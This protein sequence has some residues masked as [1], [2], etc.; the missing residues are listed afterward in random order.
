[1]LA[2]ASFPIYGKAMVNAVFG[3]DTSVHV[4]GAKRR[5]ASPFNF[6]TQQL[7]A[8]VFLAVTSVVGIWQPDGQRLH[9]ALLWN[10]LKHVRPRCLRPHAPSARAGTTGREEKGLPP[11]GSAKVAAEAAARAAS[12]AQIGSGCP[13]GPTRVCPRSP[14]P[15]DPRH[16]SGRRG[17]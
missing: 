15:A 8:F 12:N 3:K 11:K 5:K 17:P 7:M 10:L 16:Q 1:M 14:R 6:I 2:A 9:L 4:T 13:S